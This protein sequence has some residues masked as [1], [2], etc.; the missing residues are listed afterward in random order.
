VALMRDFA[1]GLYR[2]GAPALE[3]GIVDVRDVAEA[4][5]RAG[6]MPEA[7]GRHVLVSETASLLDIGAILRARFGDGYPFPDVVLPKPVVM[8]GSLFRGVALGFVARNVGYPLHFDNAHARAALGI[9][10]RPVAE[11][12]VDHF[13]QLLDDGLIPRR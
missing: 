8:V 4:H 10:F 1:T 12:V 6:V 2:F 9:D 13:R 11:T 7:S 5:V 3:F